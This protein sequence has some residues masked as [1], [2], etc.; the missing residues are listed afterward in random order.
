MRQ[1]FLGDDSVVRDCLEPRF[2]TEEALMQGPASS[3]IPAAARA[4]YVGL[5]AALIWDL[6]AQG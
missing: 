2:G 1:L 5:P 4:A 3:F 6:S